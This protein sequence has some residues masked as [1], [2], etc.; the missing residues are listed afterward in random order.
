L[1]RGGG[2]VGFIPNRI[3]RSPLT[4]DQANWSECYSRRPPS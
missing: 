4:D 2:D 1:P 3:H